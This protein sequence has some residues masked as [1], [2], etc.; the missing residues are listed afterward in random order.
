MRRTLSSGIGSLNPLRATSFDLEIVELLFERLFRIEVTG[1]GALTATPNPVLIERVE[2]SDDRLTWE[3]TL[4][5]GLTW[6]DGHP[7][8]AEDVAFTW[9]QRG[10]DPG[11]SI[12]SVEA[13]GERRIAITFRELVATGQWELDFRIVPKHV[14]EQLG[15]DAGELFGQRPVG[16]GPYRWC[17]TSSKEL[18]VVERWDGY[19]GPR[20]YFAQVEF[21]VLRDRDVRLRALAEGQV[22][23]AELSGTEFRWW[24]NGESFEDRVVKVAESQWA[25]EFVCWNAKGPTALFAN[26]AVRRAMTHAMN[27]DR[28]VAQR[29]GGLYTRCTGIHAEN[30]WMFNREVLPLAYDPDEAGRLLDEAGWEL[31]DDGGRVRQ[32]CGRSFEFAL[33]VPEESPDSRSLAHELQ[34]DLLEVGVLMHIEVL[35]WPAV[36]AR[37]DAGSFDAFIG[38]VRTSPHPDQERCRWTTDGNLNYGGYSCAAVDELYEAAHRELDPSRHPEQYRRIQALVYRDQPYTFLWHRPTL[39]AVNRNL[40][41]VQAGPLGVTGFYPGARVWW[42]PAPTR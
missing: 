22:D 37:R 7:F 29:F 30:S 18:V 16:T 11:S 10:Q 36:C 19:A 21:Q 13:I 12:E 3:V 35:P 15:A 23:V 4:Q 41:G 1:G 39:L 38:R 40:K 9:Q 25:Y 20:P 34:Q 6:H 32:C 31:P 33:L 5:G 8:T 24:V 2:V 42:M 28:I 26:A 17:P 14:F 27:L